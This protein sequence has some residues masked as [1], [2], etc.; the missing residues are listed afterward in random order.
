M[1]VT[2]YYI[3]WWC[4]L[5]YLATFIVVHRGFTG[6]YQPVTPIYVVFGAGGVAR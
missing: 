1:P 6:L 3:L 5:S 4:E 2:L